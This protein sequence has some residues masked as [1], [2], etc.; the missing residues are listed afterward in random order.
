MF[1]DGQVL[2]LDD[3]QRFAV[4]GA[5][6]KVWKTR[7][8]DKGHEAELRLVGDAIANAGEWPIALWQQIQ[9]TEIALEVEDQLR[10]G[11]R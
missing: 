5:K 11:A 4:S 6:A 7:I 9:A 1:V 10:H 2:S 8:A 3:Y